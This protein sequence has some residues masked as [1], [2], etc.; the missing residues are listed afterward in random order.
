M[1]DLIMG[2]K[3]ANDEASYKR[4]TDY[5][6]SHGVKV[7]KGTNL[8]YVYNSPVKGE[9]TPPYDIIAVAGWHGDLGGTIEPLVSNGA[10]YTKLLGV[11][12]YGFIV[13]KGYTH[14]SCWTSDEKWK[15]ILIELGFT[16]CSSNSSR[17]VK[18]VL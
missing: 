12:M 15:D 13:S 2:I 8:F 6:E 11:F 10:G 16:V 14:V 18:A 4:C 1:I 9:A 17:L 7:L 5:L 3:F